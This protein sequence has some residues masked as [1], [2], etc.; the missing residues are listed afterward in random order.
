MVLDIEQSDEVLLGLQELVGRPVA[1][2]ALEP[3]PRLAS[4]I[5]L[6]RL[7]PALDGLRV[8]VLDLMVLSLWLEEG[9]A[10]GFSDRGSGE[11]R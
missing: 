5:E 11:R 4:R 3:D 6:E 1:V 8:L 2:S 9:V 7:G 10:R